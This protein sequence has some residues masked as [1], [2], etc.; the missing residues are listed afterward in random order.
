MPY[1]GIEDIYNIYPLLLPKIAR[2]DMNN[3]SITISHQLLGTVA[4]IRK[5]QALENVRK[6]R[7]FLDKKEGSERFL[8]GD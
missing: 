8:L 3:V 7:V 1:H 6:V 2:M 5:E 4:F